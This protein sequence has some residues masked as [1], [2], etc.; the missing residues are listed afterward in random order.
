[1]TRREKGRQLGGRKRLLETCGAYRVM[2]CYQYLLNGGMLCRDRRV[3][4]RVICGISCS[5]A[6]VAKTH[7]CER[8]GGGR[9]RCEALL[10]VYGSS[11]KNGCFGNHWDHWNIFV[12]FR[13]LRQDAQ[14]EGRLLYLEFCSNWAQRIEALGDGEEGIKLS[15]EKLRRGGRRDVVSTLPLQKGRILGLGFSMTFRWPGLQIVAV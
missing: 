1:M 13:G 5:I 8:T 2:L 7:L 12:A 9:L 4:T 3:S 15:G 14:A 11:R 10:S 6:K